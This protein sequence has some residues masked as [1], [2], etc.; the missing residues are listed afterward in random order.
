MSKVFSAPKAYIE[1]DSV[2]AGYVQN[3][4]W[5]E[6]F[7]R[8]SVTGLGSLIEQ[9]APV[10]SQRNTFNVGTFFISLDEQIIKKVL[11]RQATVEEYI[12]TLSL[13]E[14]KFSVVVYKKTITNVDKSVKLIT[15]IN[16]TGETIVRLRDCVLDSQN[17]TI[18]E[19]GIAMFNI[20]GRYF[21]PVTT[22]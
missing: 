19:G 9:E 22:K 2:P 10:V 6:N 8:Q 5:S 1:I 3:L 20:A 4:S 18:A 12:N 15:E 17:W 11:N 14:F 13:D 16:K 21:T 7:Q